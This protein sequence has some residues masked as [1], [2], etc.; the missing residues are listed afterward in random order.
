MFDYTT[1]RLIWWLLLGV[2]L[3]TFAIMDGFDLGAVVLLPWVARTDAEK[4]IVINTVGPVWEGNQVWIILGAG[5]IFAAW[6]YVYAAAFSG[7]YLAMFIALSGFILRPVSFKYRS[8]VTHQTWRKTWDC[9]LMLS[10]LLPT[11]IFGVA[12]GNVIEGVPFHF[13]D[14]L[15]FFYTGTFWALLNP[16]ALLCGLL[17]IA[18]LSMH[19]AVYLCTKTLTHV[20]IRARK[21][22]LITASV[23]IVLFFIG[24]IWVQQLAHYAF[25]HPVLTDAPSNP[26]HKLMR[27][28]SHHAF[29]N[30]VSYP[31]FILAPLCGFT[32]ALL[33]ILLLSFKQYRS[34]FLSSAL[35]IF[36][37]IA[38]VGV[39]LFPVLL[40]SSS[41]PSQSLLIWDASS[42][43]STLLLMLGVGIVF[44]PIIIAYTTWVYRVMRGPVNQ[45]WLADNDKVS[46]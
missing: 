8:K 13:D 5:A 25:V 33:T 4:R 2:L 42:S 38:T 12:M 15:R 7:F 27:I 31:L 14:M 46:Y 18:M 23:V 6:P 41:D 40:P 43:K 36:G 11:L 24:G 29:A 9:L 28:E 20:Q 45:A 32:G 22:G 16:F 3:I 26:L 44:L 21:A 34:A 35:C 1:L 37:I 39:S 19:G 17:S 10:G 30:Y